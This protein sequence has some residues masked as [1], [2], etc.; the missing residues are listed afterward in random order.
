LQFI[1]SHEKNKKQ[2]QVCR[3]G[4]L[5][6][7]VS[8]EFEVQYIQFQG[9]IQDEI[10]LSTVKRKKNEKRKERRKMIT[11]CHRFLVRP[12]PMTSPF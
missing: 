10:S 4:L 7:R 8:L 3:I 11:S 9:T 2:I 6:C 5:G 12:F 1:I